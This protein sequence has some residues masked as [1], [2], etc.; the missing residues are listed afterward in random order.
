VIRCVFFF[1]FAERKTAALFA[2]ANFIARFFEL[3][4]GDSFQSAARREQCGFVDHIGKFCTGITRGAARHDCEIDAFGQ[5]HFLGVDPQNFFAS[6]HVRQ[7]DGDLAIET[8][9]PQQGRIQNIGAVRCGDD[10]HAFLRIEAIHLH[11][12]RI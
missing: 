9:G 11:E 1:F 5:F 6:F 7:I 4:E 2:P 10:D 12:Q 3:G 8:S